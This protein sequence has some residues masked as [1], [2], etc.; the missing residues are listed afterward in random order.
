M[1]FRTSIIIQG[2]VLGKFSIMPSADGFAPDIR[3]K[4][5]RIRENTKRN[6]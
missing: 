6:M 1:K 3:E 5:K 4:T 2:A